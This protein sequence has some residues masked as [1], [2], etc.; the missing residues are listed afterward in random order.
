MNFE[1]KNTTK[2]SKK[3][4]NKNDKILLL[5][6]FIIFIAIIV[7]IIVVINLQNTE[8]QDQIF[9]EEEKKEEIKLKILDLNSK[10][11]P[12]AVMID[13]NIGSGLHAGLQDSYLNY[14]IIVEGGLTRIMALFKDKDVTEIGPVRSA[15]H[16]FLDYSLESD[17]IYTHF[18]WSPYAERDI[19]S[20]NVK[21]INGLS[22]ETVFWRE[23]SIKAPHNV[24]TSTNKIKKFSESREYSL[25]STN[26][27]LLNYSAKRVNLN[28]LEN[29]EITT[30]NKISMN[31]SPSE[32]RGYIYDNE[33]EYY[34]RTMNGREHL[35]KNTRNQLN[36][37]NIIIEK[38]NNVNLDNDGRQ[39]LETTG[40][41]TGFYITNGYATKINWTKPSRSAKTKYTYSDGTEIKIN[42]GN[43]F[44]QIVP[45]TSNI[46]IE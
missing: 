12:I 36:Y 24:F 43:T 34:L 21:N 32:T 22:N 7:L 29:Q 11:R 31:Y 18:G 44:I 46:V 4:R 33:N 10:E 40:S 42:D 5:S 13:N 38:V 26:W 3:R 27:K 37:K 25:T 19:K 9:P 1:I 6:M 30:A 17:A 20:L 28:E 39:D 23:P 45:S 41:G 35:D 8:N 14:E 2:K 15:R 16:Y